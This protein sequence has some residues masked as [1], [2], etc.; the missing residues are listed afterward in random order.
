MFE[1]QQ[2]NSRIVKNTMYLYLRMLVVLVINLYT[3]RI[4]LQA[5][6]VEDYGIYNVVG[7]VVIFM[8]FLNSVLGNGTTRFITFEM[9]KGDGNV[10]RVFQS[11]IISH[12]ILA[13]IIILFA[14]TAGLWF[15]YHKLVIAPERME[16]ASFTYHC[17]ILTSFL[18]ISLVPYT[19]MI[20][21]K[22]RMNVYA[23]VSILDAFLKLT[24]VFLLYYSPIDRLKYY[25]FLL[26]IEQVLIISLYYIYCLKHYEETSLMGL[27]ADW[28]KI[29]EIVSFS[30]WSIFGNAA[31]ALNG[32]GLTIITNI[33][34][35]PSVVVARVLSVQVY[36]AAMNIINNIGKAATPQIIKLQASG[37]QRLSQTL[38]LN[39]TRYSFL[40]LLVVIVPLICSC[41][42]IMQLWLVD[43][44]G[45]TVI[46]VQLIL[47]QSMFY[48]FDTC[49]YV[50]LYACGKV[51]EN[52]LISPTLYFIQFIVIFFLFYQGFSPISLSIVCVITCF[53]SGV[54]FKPLLLHKYAEY[55]YKRV[56]CLLIRCFSAVIIAF[57]LPVYFMHTLGSS[58]GDMFMKV[59]I[60]I[61]SAMIAVVT[62][63]ITR[64]ERIYIVKGLPA[65]LRNIWSIYLR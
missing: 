34:F 36:S 25:A 27:K 62:V 46:F 18:N 56:C 35:S 47:I 61:C 21:S 17:T 29:K 5:L 16:A 65:K 3:S 40:M 59:A 32:Q 7:G 15:L 24:I 33:F 42:E 23:I 12:A 52:A 8:S 41:K 9:G 14:E 55:P 13:L 20:I 31:T 11:A 37:E 6:G 57:P 48:T 50:G 28:G 1:Y 38:M 26:L 39:T 30:S 51:K 63:G 45:Y 19:A 58:I 53:V 4:V 64:S 54:C 43:V 2:S 10:N 44:P 22:E 60:S 49:F